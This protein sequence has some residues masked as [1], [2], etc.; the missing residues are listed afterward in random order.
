MGDEPRLDRI[1]KKLDDEIL[2]SAEFRGELRQYMVSR[3]GYTKAVSAQVTSIGAMCDTKTT[4]VD[5][6]LQDHKADSNA[7]GAGIKRDIDGKIIGWATL[8]VTLLASF[9]GVIGAAMHKFWSAP[10]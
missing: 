7:H 4:A 9:G 3:D 6:D 8:G 2:A 5:K 10:K 1:E